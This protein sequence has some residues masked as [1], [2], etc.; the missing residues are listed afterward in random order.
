MGNES[1]WNKNKKVLGNFNCV[2]MDRDG[3]NKTQ[4]L[5]R[6]G[7]NY[8]LSKFI[9][10]NGFEDLWR[11]EDSDSSELTHFDRSSGAQDPG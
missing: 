3:G 11:R 9:V 8:A 6:Y 1:E 4:R 10:D 5:I 7:S 2:K